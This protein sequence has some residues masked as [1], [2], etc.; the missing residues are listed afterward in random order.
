MTK[1]KLLIITGSF[2]NGHI[3]ATE[4]IMSQIDLNEIDVYKHDLFLEAHPLLT[5]VAKTYYINS[6][7]HFRTSYKMF[8]YSRPNAVDKS[9]YKYYGL[10]KLLKLV[11]EYNPDLILVTFPTPVMSVLKNRL[12]I[13]IPIVTVITDYRLH[14]NWVTPYS[15]G[16]YVACNETKNDLMKVGV[17][18][19]LIHVT[20][21]P[22]NEAFSESIDCEQW[23]KSFNLDPNKKTIL[24]VAGAFG[25]LRGFDEMI[26]QLIKKDENRQIVVVCGRNHELAQQLKNK[27]KNYSQVLIM[28][29][30]K[31][32]NQWMASCDI[33]ITKPGGITIS[34]ALARKIPLILYNP[35]PGQELENAKY[36]N[37]TR[38]AKIANNPNET[39]RIADHLLDHPLELKHMQQSMETHRKPTASRHIASL[40]N[41]QLTKSYH[42][43]LQDKKV[44]KYAKLF[45]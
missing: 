3:Q 15:E 24:M 45:S 35:A 21:I 31:E 44:I 7:T 14:K 33:M 2:G 4:S 13:D 29:Y 10:N 23:L 25:V 11:A 12:N 40:I 19:N 38:L 30:T 43:P 20:G 22:I 26:Q 37:R 32:M 8:Y 16:Y 1:K 27:F 28:G 17:D 34:E 36:F 42:K 41:E 5:T 18:E 39:I 9:F 6:F